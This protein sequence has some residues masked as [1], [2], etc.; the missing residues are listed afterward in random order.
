VPRAA[1]SQVAFWEGRKPAPHGPYELIGR[2]LKDSPRFPN[3]ACRRVNPEI[4]DAS[5]RADAL[6]ALK[7][8]VDCPVLEQCYRWARAQDSQLRRQGWGSGLD[9]ICGGE[10]WGSAR[11]WLP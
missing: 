6:A 9:G 1:D 5:T 7:L 8:C 3:A 10:L 11:R 4:F 2:I